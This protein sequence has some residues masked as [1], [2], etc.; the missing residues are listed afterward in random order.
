VAGGEGLD[1]Q[2][3]NSLKQYLT[4]GYRGDTIYGSEFYHIITQSP[5]VIPMPPAGKLSDCD[6]SKIDRWLKKG[7]PED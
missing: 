2:N 7:A 4:N 5:G 6:I 1:L 3:F